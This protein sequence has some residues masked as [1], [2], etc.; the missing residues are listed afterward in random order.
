MARRII[1][2]GEDLD[3]Y[4]DEKISFNLRVNSIADISNRNSSSSNSILIPRTGKNR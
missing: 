3:L 4:H 1:V 2:N